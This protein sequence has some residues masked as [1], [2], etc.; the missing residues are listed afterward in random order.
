LKVLVTDYSD[1]CPFQGRT[2][3]RYWI[4][5]EFEIHENENYATVRYYTSTDFPMCPKMGTWESCVHCMYWDDDACHYDGE[6]ISVQQLE[7]ILRL[8]LGNRDYEIK[9]S[10]NEHFVTLQE[11]R[12][13]F[14][15]Y[16]LPCGKRFE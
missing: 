8:C 7:E 10:F 9:C 5:R 1:F 13:H 12:G 6:R 11:S 3:G 4:S 2:G 14:R 16:C 15:G